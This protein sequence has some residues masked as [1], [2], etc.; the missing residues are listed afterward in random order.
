MT[1]LNEIKSAFRQADNTVTQLIIINVIVFA[2]LSTS[3]VI[4]GISGQTSILS[5]IQDIFLLPSDF[6]TF[7]TRPWTLITY[8][9]SHQ[10]LFHI[11]FNMLFLYWFGRL[12]SE[13]LGSQKLLALY[14]LGGLAGGAL[15]LFMYNYI[16]FYMNRGASVLLGASASVYAIMVA[17]ATLLPDYTIRLFLIGNVKLKWMVAVYLFIS[18]LGIVGSNAGGD[19]A[20]LGGALMG[21]LYIK[22]LQK[23]NDLG[24]P[25]IKTI[26][27]FGN[28]FKPKSHVKVSYK[29]S[30]KT[31]QSRKQTTSSSS[32]NPQQSEIDTILDKISESGYDS[33]TKAEKELL[34]SASKK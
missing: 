27:W 34:F 24:K 5:F 17:A 23:G 10:G 26:N 3:T 14:F 15:Y 22:S 11:L 12:I 28:L 33:L 32:V 31:K 18:F 4:L 29:E 21:Y 19:L 6:D 13:F 20:H 8:A 25:I 1:I 30:K 7:I 2:F 16:P 9:F